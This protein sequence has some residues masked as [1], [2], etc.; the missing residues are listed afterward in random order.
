V[1]NMG[2]WDDAM[3]ALFLDPARNA[4]TCTGFNYDSG[5]AAAPDL[6]WARKKNTKIGLGVSLEQSVARDIGA[7]FRA[8][9]SDGKTEVYAYTATDSSMSLGAIMKG[10][11]WGRTQDTAGL[12]YAQNWI[13]AQH[14]AY[15]NLGGIDGFIGDGRISYK[16]E[17]AVEAYYNIGVNRHV[18]LTLDFQHI[19]NPA[20]NADRGP[21]A[22][23]GA[24]LHAE[25]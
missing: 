3:N 13:S 6:C 19:A 12:G 25:F 20:Y 22:L 4:T 2:R 14:V 15:L 11:R 17:R 23:Y 24:R 10:T 16:P 21:V 7:F 5:N 18:W 1:E 8:M 9:K